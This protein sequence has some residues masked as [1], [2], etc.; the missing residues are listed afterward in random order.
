MWELIEKNKRRSWILL[1]LMGLILLALGY[2]IGAAV[3]VDFVA[4]EHVGIGMKDYGRLIDTLAEGG[5]ADQPPR[6]FSWLDQPGKLLNAGGLVG[7]GVAMVI[8]S[9]LAATA[10][11]AGDKTILWSMGA[12]EIEREDAPRLWNIVEEM[13]IASGLP[14]P[15]RVFLIDD[16][17]M[18][19]F[20][21]GLTPDKAS[22]AFTTGLVRRLNR[23]ELQG[24]AAHEIAHVYNYDVRFMTLASVM[25]GSIVMISEMFL[26]TLWYS[27]PRRSSR[28]K[29]GGG[30]QAVLMIV[31]ILFAILAP[32]LAH[33]LYFACSRRRE[34]LADACAARF[35][36]YPPGL[37]SAL[38]KLGREKATS[39]EINRGVVPLFIVNPLQ[40]FSS[41]SVFSSHPPLEKR[42][43]VLKSMAG[44][45][46]IDYERAYES[47]FRGKNTLLDSSLLANE[48]SQRMR[49]PSPEE[50]QADSIERAREMLDVFDRAASFIFI[51]CTC[52]VRLKVPPGMTRDEVACPKCG[53]GHVVPHAEPAAPERMH[54]SE[55]AV[56]YQR[57][58]D[59]WESFRCACGKT[60]Q[61]S[62][63]FSARLASCRACGR[64]VQIIPAG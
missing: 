16:E 3:Y 44:A 10:L 29:E 5:S 18:N 37:A 27:A 34:Y 45:G 28:S 46:L 51:T 36:R 7:T 59:G 42:I 25:V 21:V 13:T 60:I 63:K 6:F 61:L 40:P 43:A 4:V 41:S 30:A 12:R 56:T 64:H 39:R 19:A 57:T 15:P 22:V 1:G 26:R 23:D 55:A 32:I 33:L 2:V 35:T 38:S 52:G 49:D 62:P 24:V 54:E 17:S 58:G 14:K 11:F 20:A 50:E 8:W 47:V 31:A 48:Q 9:I 53:R